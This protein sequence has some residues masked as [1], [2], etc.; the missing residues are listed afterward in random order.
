MP[1][2][3]YIT[4]KP[5]QPARLVEASSQIRQ[6]L[7]H[8]LHALVQ[9]IVPKGMR[10]CEHILNTHN[11]IHAHNSMSLVSHHLDCRVLHHIGGQEV[12]ES[13]QGAVL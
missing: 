11:S 6:L 10:R 8:M 2:S 5:T 12:L 7:L 9:H 13:I 1:P 4:S 3:V